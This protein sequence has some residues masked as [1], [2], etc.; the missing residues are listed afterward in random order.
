LEKTHLGDVRVLP[1]MV[2]GVMIWTLGCGCTGRGLGSRLH[3]RRDHRGHSEHTET[4][5]T[6]NAP[7]CNKRY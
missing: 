7:R 5:S 6:Y 2:F 1:G 3:L 4:S